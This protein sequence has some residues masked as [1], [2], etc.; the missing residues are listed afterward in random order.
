M[1]KTWARRKRTTLL[2]VVIF[3]KWKRNNDGRC[4]WLE[5]YYCQLA[6]AEIIESKIAKATTLEIEFIIR[7]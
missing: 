6:E 2:F 3:G 1:A 4:T 7:D 5:L